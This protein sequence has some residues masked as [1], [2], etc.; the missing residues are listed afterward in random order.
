M[1]LSAKKDTSEGRVVIKKKSFLFREKNARKKYCYRKSCY[2]LAP[3]GA[4]SSPEKHGLIREGGAYLR[5]G[6][7]RGFTVPV[8]RS[9]QYDDATLRC[10]SEN[11]VEQHDHHGQRLIAVTLDIVLRCRES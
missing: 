8:F 3:R 6:V 9:R 1:G 4:Y 10:T 11:G 2:V 7:N 5:G